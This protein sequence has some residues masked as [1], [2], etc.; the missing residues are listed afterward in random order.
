MKPA[1]DQREQVRTSSRSCIAEFRFLESPVLGPVTVGAM[2][3]HSLVIGPEPSSV[4]SRPHETYLNPCYWQAWISWFVC[5]S[6][7][8]SFRPPL[9]TTVRGE[10]EYYVAKQIYCIE[11]SSPLPRADGVLDWRSE[12]YLHAR[13]DDRDLSLSPRTSSRECSQSRKFIQHTLTHECI[14]VC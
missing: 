14:N 2:R 12:Q 11:T 1:Q 4:Y 6:V 13:S 3:T 9:C 7:S 8:G 5:T 10:L